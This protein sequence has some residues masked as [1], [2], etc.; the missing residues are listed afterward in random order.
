[1]LEVDPGASPEAIKNAYKELALTLHPDKVRGALTEAEATEAMKSVND[2]RDVL[3]GRTPRARPTPATPTKPRKRPRAAAPATP[4]KWKFKRVSRPR[5]D[6]ALVS[7]KGRWE[8]STGGGYTARFTL[9]HKDPRWPGIEEVV[10]F[11]RSDRTA[12]LDFGDDR[13]F[14]LSGHVTLNEWQGQ[15]NLKVQDDRAFAL[16]PRPGARSCLSCNGHIDDTEPSWKTR[17]YDCWKK[18]KNNSSEARG[19]QNRQKMTILPPSTAL[20]PSTTFNRPQPPSITFNRPQPPSTARPLGLG[21]LHNRIARTG[22]YT[23]A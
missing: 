14:A 12:D 15:T 11:D 17:C 4:S 19:V 22:P 9:V 6:G 2:A 23:T 16:E 10:F 5:L 3:L 1:M 21:H 8:I 18:R 13:L 7:L 20:N